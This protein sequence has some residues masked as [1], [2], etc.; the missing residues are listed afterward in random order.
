MSMGMGYGPDH[1]AQNS[2][3][4]RVELEAIRGEVR[5]KA[6][7]TLRSALARY[8]DETLPVAVEE[9]AR[10]HGRA[11]GVSSDPARRGR[12]REIHVRPA[13]RSVQEGRVG[14]ASCRG[15]EIPGRVQDA[16]PDG[17]A[18]QRARPGVRPRRAGPCRRVRGE[19]DERPKVMSSNGSDGNGKPRRARTPSREPAARGRG[20]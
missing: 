1:A 20:V 4:A 14:R 15:V 10:V 16:V 12:G 3:E 19:G 13:G 9:I 17:E 7:E 11:L 18:L 2:P 6:D 8:A 5:A